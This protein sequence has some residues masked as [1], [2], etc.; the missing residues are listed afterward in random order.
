LKLT[1]HGVR[2]SQDG[3]RPTQGKTLAGGQVA[4]KAFYEILVPAAEWFKPDLILVSTGFDPHCHDLALNVSYG[5]IAEVEA[6]AAF[7]RG[8]FVEP[9]ASEDPDNVDQ[10]RR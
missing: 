7:H 9:E 6:A 4:L 10:A 3:D 1:K 8:A 5:G 2:R